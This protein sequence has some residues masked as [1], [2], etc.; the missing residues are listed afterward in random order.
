MV[1]VLFF[2]DKYFHFVQ[3]LISSI[4]LHEPDAK[5]YV[6]AFN[7]SHKQIK[8]IKNCTN[9][10]FVINENIKFDPKIADEFHSGLNKGK[11]LRFQLTCQRGRYLLDAM[12]ALPNEDLF[13]I[14]D[15]D[16]LMVNPLTELK[17]Q[18]KNHDI[19]IVRVSESK[20]CSGF[21]AARRTKKAKNYLK[22]FYRTAMNGRLFF[23]KDQQSLAKVY[24]NT[25]NR[26][27]FLMIDRRYLDNTR[28]DNSFMWS[29]HKSRSGTKKFK[30]Q[31]YKK[32]LRRMVKYKMII[33]DEKFK[34][35]LNVL[36]I[37]HK[38]WAN[39]GQMISECLNKIGV[40]S[41][42]LVKSKHKFE[43]P[44]H[45]IYFKNKS[46]IEQYAK[47]ANIIIFMHS[48]YIPLGDNLKNK[49]VLVWHTGSR[50]R[51]HSKNVNK[52]FNP[53]VDASICCRDV[54]GLG[55]KNEKDIPC[56]VNTNILKPNYKRVDNDKIII[57]HYPSGNKGINIIKKCIEVVQ[58][59]SLKDKF[60]FNYSE[61]RERVSWKE[62][63]ER[64]SECDVYIEEMREYQ[65]KQLLSIFGITAL[66]AA[67]LG[68]IVITKFLHLE[69]YE[70]KFGKC[71]LHIA[72]TPKELIQQIK[73]IV[74]LSDDDLLELKK[75]SRDWIVRC[76]SYEAVALRMVELFKEI[77]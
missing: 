44:T 31:E 60:R 35:N 46:Q 6:H 30:Y 56:P 8:Q 70:E 76:H 24:E 39:L 65:K 2:D 75:Q 62:Q 47:K 49:K 55:A 36:L 28:N 43:F 13:V 61:E 19:G 67:A 68:K 37:A 64:V 3:P 5:I 4:N 50:F 16:T 12:K 63:I 53:I 9:V 33:N 18:M 42:M 73:H 1:I 26:M 21:F 71:G 34:K 54:F 15:T 25:K 57:A 23:T 77:W 22:I 10:F 14:T 74:S 72:K 58:Q 59:S 7:L 45:G 41:N 66:E 17:E 48:Q 52:I 11:P 27:K 29:G 38:D 51:Q 32:K 69:E 40:E 20:I